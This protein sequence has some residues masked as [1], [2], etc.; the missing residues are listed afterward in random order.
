MLLVSDKW[1]T[2]FTGDTCC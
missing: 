2:E 1:V